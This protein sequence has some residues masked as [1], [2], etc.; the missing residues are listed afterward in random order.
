MSWSN[1]VLD[2]LRGTGRQI[3]K[4]MKQRP[5]LS[6]S[7]LCFQLWVAGDLLAQWYEHD[8]NQEHEYN[9][10]RTS[11]AAG[12]GALVTGPVYATWYP[13]LDRKC[14]AWKL[15][16][17]GVWA[18][19]IAKV[20]IDELVMDPPFISLFFTYMTWC[21]NDMK[22]DW[23]LTQQKLKSELPR[24]WVASLAVWPVVLLGTFRFVPTHFQTAVVNVCAIFWDG[25]LSHRNAASSRQPKK[26]PQQLM[27]GPPDSAMVT[28]QTSHVSIDKNHPSSVVS[29]PSMGTKDA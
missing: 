9:L 23:E 14:H 15:A 3:G 2:S 25:F 5:V 4:T 1:V 26:E 8:P 11:Q 10:L 22:L 18:V 27:E 16:Q 6:N 19:P 28:R 13:F 7:I 20:V 21:Q 17:H 29:V 12:Y 24:A